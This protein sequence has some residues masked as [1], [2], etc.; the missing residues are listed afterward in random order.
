MPIAIVN[1]FAEDFFATRKMA[2]RLRTHVSAFTAASITFFLI[3][4]YLA[5]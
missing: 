5:T 1:G 4:C 2:I 3:F